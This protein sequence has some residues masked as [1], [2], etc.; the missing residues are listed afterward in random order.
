LKEA[1]KLGFTSAIAPK[2]GKSAKV[3]GMALN[4]IADLA[5]FVGDIFGAG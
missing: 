5:Q 3:D 2:G 4:Q 1:A